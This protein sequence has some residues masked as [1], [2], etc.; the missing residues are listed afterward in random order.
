M[1]RAKVIRAG[2]GPAL[3]AVTLLAVVLSEPRTVLAAAPPNDNFANY[4]VVSGPLPYTDTIDS[5]LDATTEVNEPLYP[6]SVA[7]AIG[8][9]VWYRLTVSADARV[10]IE[11]EGSTYDTVLTVYT[12]ESLGSLTQVDCN[13]NIGGGVLQSRLRMGVTPG[14]GS[15]YI[16]VGGYHGAWGSL[17]FDVTEFPPPHDDF[18]S[19][20]TIGSIPFTDDPLSTDAATTEGS[21]PLQPS[22]VGVPIGKTVW[23][24]YA[25]PSSTV[26]KAE[27]LPV[28]GQYDT[29][30]AAYTGP[31]YGALSEVGCDDDSGS[32]TLSLLTFAATGGTTY[33]MQVGGYGGASGILEFSLS[34]APPTPT[35]TR[36]RTPTRTPTRTATPTVTP[37]PTPTFT[38]T[39]AATPT[40]TPTPTPVINHLAGTVGVF[41]F[42]GDGGQAQNALLNDP[43]GSFEVTRSDTLYF[44]DTNNNRVRGISPNKPSGIIT[45]VAGG[46]TPTPGYCGEGGPATSACLDHPYDVFVDGPGNL[47]I[48]DTGNNRIRKVNTAGTITTVAGGG[49]GCVEPCPATQ[50]ALSGPRG[51]AVDA[52]GNIYIADTENHRIRRVDAA[53]GTITT[54]AGDGIAGFSGDGVLATATHL[55]RPHDVYIYGRFGDFLI[56]DTAN[57]RIRLVDGFTGVILTFAGSGFAGYG[58]DGGPA[59]LAHLYGPEAVAVDSADLRL[60]NVLIADTQNHRIRRVN[61]QTSVISTVAG[62]GTPGSGGDGGDPTLAQL[63]LPAGIAVGSLTGSDTGNSTLRMIDPTTGEPGGKFGGFSC[64]VGSVSTADWVLVG[65]VLGLVL[66]RRRVRGLILWIWAAAPPARRRTTG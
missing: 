43:H 42:D 7:Y 6:C 65:L 16:Q 13:D 23:Y 48:A 59:T 30:L 53:S 20:E 24:D 39:P 3:A 5:T 15:Y 34:E 2:V 14:D 38:A 51:V 40:P 58:G 60:P 55:N 49:P 26:L 11:T 4:T 57:N 1:K 45:T 35:P 18:A 25:P 12:G 28:S 8:K 62:N 22:C 44:A 9:T 37:T 64:T 10:Q 61:G 31:G 32:G 17:V 19:A 56:A 66:A 33:H 21:E 47:Y 29:V 50:Q 41:D 52:T 54:V 46:G 27:T 36:T 63:N